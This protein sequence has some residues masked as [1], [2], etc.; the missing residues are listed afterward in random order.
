MGRQVMGSSKRD[1]YS[2]REKRA[3][4]EAAW[5]AIGV[6]LF[7]IIPILSWAAASATLEEGMKRGWLIPADM[8]GFVRF[9]PEAYT[10][11]GINTIVVWLGS[12]ENLVGIVVLTITYLFLLGGLISFIYSVIYRMN[13]PR[14]GKFDAPPPKHKAK[15]YKR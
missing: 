14:Y 4:A 3:P 11:P 7:F 13:V 10:T 12:I 6:A 2:L 15:K 9:P 5:R 8:I 1:E